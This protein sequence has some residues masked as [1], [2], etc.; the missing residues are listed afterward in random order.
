M[1]TTPPSASAA[2]VRVVRFGPD[3]T[4]LQRPEREASRAPSLFALAVG[5]VIITLALTFSLVLAEPLLAGTVSSSVRINAKDFGAVGDGVRDD[6]DAVRAACLAAARAGGGKVYLPPGTYRFL[7]VAPPSDGVEGGQLPATTFN[8]EIPSGVSVV[9]AGIAKTT[10]IAARSD[11]HPFGADHHDHVGLSHLSITAAAGAS[12]VDGAKFMQ[13]DRVSI[14]HVQAKRLYIGLALYSCS[15]STISKSSAEDCSAFGFCSGEA[16]V[17]GYSGRTQNVVIADCRG[18]GSYINF[19]V[20]GTMKSVSA[21][22]TLRP[23]APLR[24]RGTTLFACLSSNA[25]EAGY[26]LSYAEDAFVSFC[27]DDK[28]NWQGIVATGVVDSM[29]VACTP[30]VTQVSQSAPPSGYGPCSGNRTAPRLGRPVCPTAI[31]RG[32][33]FKVSGVLKP[34]FPAGGTVVRVRVYRYGGERWK[35]VGSR[36]ARNSDYFGFSRYVARVAIPRRGKYRF[37]AATETTTF[38]QSRTSG[39]SEALTVE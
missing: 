21:P 26:H 39:Y 34:R 25:D 16:D 7:S 20:R 6:A 36:A 30:K 8:V 24:N 11:A 17:L 18:R 9:G 5:A 38:W 23:D 14:H 3:A 35:L 22:Y 33:T 19:R 32:T 4:G 1:R 31:R 15:N 29:F 2:S 12:N 13:C 27:K 37:E 28:T 10:V